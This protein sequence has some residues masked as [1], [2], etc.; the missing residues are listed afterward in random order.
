[1]TP[2]EEDRVIWKVV[3]ASML[4][5]MAAFFFTDSALA[6]IVVMIV[7]SVVAAI[8]ISETPRK[9]VSG[10]PSATLGPR[11]EI[12]EEDDQIM[13]A[14]GEEPDGGSANR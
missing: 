6:A 10:F 14:I 8:K 5:S 13:L 2:E 3:L 7:F 11:S 9:Y 4:L 12:L 1:M